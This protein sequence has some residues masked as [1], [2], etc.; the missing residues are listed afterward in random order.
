MTEF[1]SLLPKVAKCSVFLVVYLFATPLSIAQEGGAVWK[2]T[3]PEIR[4]VGSSECVDC[5]REQYASYLR[6]AHSKSAARTDP[7]QEPPS[8]TFTQAL[9]GFRYEI[10]R[11]DG[12]LIHR[13]VMRDPSGDPIAETTRA[14]TLTLGSGTHAKSYLYQMGDFLGQSPVTWY[15]E[16]NSWDMSPGFDKARHFSFRRTVGTGCVFC[17]VGVIDRKEFNP[18]HFEIVETAIGCERCHGPGELHV[19]RHRSND[20]HHGPNDDIVNP[21]RL[22]RSLAEAICQQCHLQGAGKAPVTNQD[23]WDFRPGLPLTDFHI[24][25]QIRFKDEPMRI[26]GHV[27]QMHASECY[28]QTET[29]TCTTCHHPHAPVDDNDRIDFHRSACL[30]CHEDQ[31]CG[32]PLEKRIEL[33]DNSCFECHMPRSKTNVTHAALHHHRIGIHGQGGDLQEADDSGLKPIL[34]ISSL[35]QRERERCLA[36]AKIGFIR[37]EPLRPQQKQFE[38]EATQAL[39]QLINTG[40]L[41]PLA[42]SQ[43]AWLARKQGQRAIAEKLASD[44]LTREKRPTMARIEATEILAETALEKQK[45]KQAAD[46][47][48]Q[49]NGYYRNSRNAFY[50]GI[51]LNNLGEV[52]NAITTL[53]DL[54]EFDPSQTSAHAALRAIYQVRNQ[55][56]KAAH[57]EQML[58]KLTALLQLLDSR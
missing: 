27:E 11:T 12:N 25:Y 39:I 52:D 33:T 45:M 40:D 5:H 50:L 57:H 14:M 46:L 16:T 42:V 18:Y 6:T 26:V 17:H 49:A 2:N 8:A 41:D 55:P 43:M 13:E 15:R 38:I 20:Q 34:D 44:V 37:N 7:D 24:D 58:L 32:E 53:E 36:L 28:K 22:D 54:I 1:G 19:K 30:K 56:E 31:S 10:E 23:L 48:R 51:C 35:P 9:T 21:E 3:R 29:L 47:F 4:Y